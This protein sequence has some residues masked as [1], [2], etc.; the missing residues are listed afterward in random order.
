MVL[1]GV[2]LGM[3]SIRSDQKNYF[4]IP[5]PTTAELAFVKY[6]G[7]I[8]G[9]SRKIFS[10]RLDSTTP[11]RT[12]QVTKKT[13]IS[14]ERGK[15]TNGRGGRAIKIPTELTS[16]PDSAPTTDPGSAVI[17][18]AQ[19]RYTTIRFPNN[20]SIGEISAW[21]HAKLAS[22]K[23]KIMKSPGGKT[24]AVSPLVAGATVTGANTTP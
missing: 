22:H 6:R 2:F 14:R 11:T 21:L 3:I 13:G 23:P 19:V 4:N 10:S 20:A 9:H 15:S 17:K 24:Y 5:D 18:R 1:N 8:K 16:T 7:E 12:V